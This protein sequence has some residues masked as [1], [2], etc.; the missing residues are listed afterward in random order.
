MILIVK[1]LADR[2]E[3]NLP[4]KKIRPFLTP[5]VRLKGFVVL[6]LVWI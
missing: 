6:G 1:D 2:P 4:R 3:A 5:H